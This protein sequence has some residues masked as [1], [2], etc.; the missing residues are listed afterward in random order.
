MFDFQK[1][2][3]MNFPLISIIVVNYNGKKYLKDF[4][5]SVRNL[6]YPQDKLEIIMVDNNSKDKSI[7]YTKKNFP[8]VKIIRNRENNYAQANNLGIKKS[9]GKFIALLNNDMVLDKNWLKELLKVITSRKKI[10]VVGSKILFM[11]KKTIQSAGLQQLPDFY[12]ADKGFKEKD[13]GQYNKIRE[14]KS[15]GGAALLYRKKCLKDVGLFDENF[16]MYL[17]DVDMA[18]RCRKAGWKLFYA[19][20]SVAYHKFRGTATKDLINRYVERNRLFLLAKH[21][22]EQFADYLYRSQF[23]FSRKHKMPEKD[24]L[25]IFKDWLNSKIVKKNLSK[26]LANL[27]ARPKEELL[28]KENAIRQKDRRIANQTTQL[29]DLRIEKDKGISELNKLLEDKEGQLQDIFHSRGW[30]FLT[31]V[32]AIKKKLGL[33]R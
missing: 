31:V 4:F 6:D 23:F 24:L 15:L 18:I 11:D 30:K 25:L 8:E 32:R 22:P 26:Y 3:K 17:E 19:P 1:S 2:E 9:K 13:K 27:V 21:F 28:K 5:N 12:W 29:K 33:T 20:K 16:V 14:V 7:E 10:G